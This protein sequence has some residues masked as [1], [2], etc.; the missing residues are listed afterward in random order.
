MSQQI[1]SLLSKL[2]DDEKGLL[3]GILLENKQF[4]HDRDELIDIIKKVVVLIGI[5]TPDGQIKP[6]IASGEEKVMKH[7][8]KALSHVVTT[9]VVNPKKIETDFEF[10]KNIM[11]LLKRYGN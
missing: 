11:P 2:S 5:A 7:I 6:E 3:T 1:N 4:K 10:I 8:L 9:M